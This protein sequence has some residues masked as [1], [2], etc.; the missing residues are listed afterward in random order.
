MNRW[1]RLYDTVV[2]EPKVQRLSD[3]LF[4]AWINLMCVA[5]RTGGII[6][7]DMRELGFRLRKPEARMRELVEQ[8]LAAGLLDAVGEDY[9]PHNWEAHQFKSDGSSERVKR[10]RKH[11]DAKN[12]TGPES[13]TESES[14][15]KRKTH[16]TRFEEFWKTCPRKVG[17]GAAEKAF[18][19][20]LKL[21]EAET[22]MAAM[23][24]YAAAQAGRDPTFTCHPATWLNQQRWLT[25]ASHRSQHPMRQA[26]MRRGRPGAERRRRWWTGSGPRPSTPI[27]GLRNLRRAHPRG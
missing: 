2:D 21:A 1:F 6:A 11:D 16:T 13:E 15:Q 9:Q 25:R 14:E 4:R 23:T 12:E 27:S 19:R 17:R 10:F 18:F 3:P 24:V 5:S 7:G 26:R 8:L 20:A 22:L